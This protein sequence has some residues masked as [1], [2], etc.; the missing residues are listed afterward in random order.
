MTDR[1][2]DT[3]SQS[4]P[5]LIAGAGIA[6]IATALALAR[7]GHAV[8]LLEKRSDP[9]EDGA[10][11]QIGPNGMRVLEAL[12]VTPFLDGKIAWPEGIRVMDGIT[13]RHLTTLPLGRIWRP[14]TARPTASYIAPIFT[15]HCARQPRA[16]LRSH[17]AKAPKSLPQPPT[18]TVSPLNCQAGETISGEFLIG[19]DGIW[20]TLRTTVMGAAPLR[21]TGKCAMRTVIPIGAVPPAISTVDTSIWLRPA[22]HVVHYP[23]RAGR[24][25]A[26][27]AIFDDPALGETCVTHSGPRTHHLARAIIPG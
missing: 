15:R 1:A 27:V 13:G 6:G 8:T 26:I 23:V 25:L 24:D 3:P 20:S 5:V 17:S 19:A 16:V 22:A 7:N 21:F 10:G 4:A 11:I 9:S 2:P 12:G 18:G 14:A